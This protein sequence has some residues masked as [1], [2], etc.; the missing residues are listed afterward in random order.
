M[1]VDKV[2]SD[3]KKKIYKPVYWIEGDEEFYVDMLVNYAEQ[4]I[5]SESEASFNLTIFYGK[6][7]QWA[8]IVNTCRKY[9]MFSDRQVVI[10]KEAHQLKDADMLA[11][12]IESPLDSTILIIACKD[13]KL[14]GRSKFAKLVKDNTVYILTKKIYDSALPEWVNTYVKGLGYTISPKANALI[15]DHIGNDLSRIKNEIDK[16]LINLGD[17]KSITEEDVEN[18]VGIS[19]EYNVFELQAAIASKDLGK[20]ISIIQY[21]GANPKMGPIQMVLP[22]LYSFFS[23]VYMVFGVGGGEDAVA[24]QIGVSPYFVKNYTQAAR[25]YGARNIEKILLLLHQ[26]NLKSVGVNTAPTEDAEL[27]KE[28]VVKI[29]A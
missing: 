4:H 25:L 19:K 2:I 28:M 6:D 23:K 13:K 10:V 12:Y 18:Y 5:L 11:P 24:K 27:M 22:S 29:M 3:W 8:D 26:Y 21:F 15:V 16:I 9:P 17:R 14:D 7:A 1:T 20:A